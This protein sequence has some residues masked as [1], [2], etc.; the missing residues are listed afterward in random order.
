MSRFC[1]VLARRKGRKIC[2]ECPQVE[3]QW[4]T[5]RLLIDLAKYKGKPLSKTEKCLLFLLLYGLSSKDIEE[6][7]GYKKKSKSYISRTIYEYVELLT[8]KNIGDWAHVRLY[9]EQKNYRRQYFNQS[10][11]KIEFK[12]EFKGEMDRGSIEKI[13][14]QLKKFNVSLLRFETVEIKGKNE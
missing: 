13:M 3:E 11:E 4:Q 1:P 8:Q 14:T 10:T 6:R 12:L 2:N 5:D 9:L 7:F